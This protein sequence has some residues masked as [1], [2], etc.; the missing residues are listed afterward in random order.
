M[1]VSPG[2]G[3]PAWAIRPPIL[4]RAGLRSTKQPRKFDSAVATD[5]C[6]VRVQPL[7]ALPPACLEQHLEEPLSGGGL[8]VG[9]QFP[10][11]PISPYCAS[12][13]KRAAQ[14]QSLP[15]PWATGSAFDQP[16]AST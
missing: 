15:H 16:T 6:P 1:G 13:P 14:P 9:A 4:G 3:R 7:P 8:G 10:E 5:G 2:G 11:H 12:H